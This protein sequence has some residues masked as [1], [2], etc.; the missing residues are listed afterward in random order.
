[1]IPNKTKITYFEVRGGGGGFSFIKNFYYAKL[2][3]IFFKKICFINTLP[4]TFLM[5]TFIIEILSHV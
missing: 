2:Q 4:L 1:M 3:K 5:G